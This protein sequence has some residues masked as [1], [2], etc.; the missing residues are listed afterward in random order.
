MKYQV[1]RKFCFSASHVIESGFEL[2]PENRLHGHNFVIRLTLGSKVL[3]DDGLVVAIG[4]LDEFQCYV[5][6]VLDRKHLNDVVDCNPT[7]ENMARYIYE[8]CEEEFWPIRSVAWS[9]TPGTWA[10]YRP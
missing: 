1:S 4:T 9:E 5:E 7:A 10:T 8:W 6:D 2:E 3:N